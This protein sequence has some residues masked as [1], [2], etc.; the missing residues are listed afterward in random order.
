[1]LILYL[2]SALKCIQFNK[3]LFSQQKMIYDLSKKLNINIEM[4]RNQNGKGKIIIPFKNDEDLS[5]V[6]NIIND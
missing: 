3:Y 4:K 6:F 2:Y 5:R 1:M